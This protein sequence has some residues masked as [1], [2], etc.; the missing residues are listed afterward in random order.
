MAAN[1]STTPTPTNEDIKRIEAILA[2]IANLATQTQS[3]LRGAVEQLP[4]D[5]TSTAGYLVGAADELAAQIGW[6]AD[7]ASE[8]LNG[9]CPGVR[10]G[11][12]Q[13]LLPPVYHEASESAQA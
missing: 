10:G 3:V 4:W 8:L 1:N 5:E 6:S 13:W 11:A 12:E 9:G 2:K 7:R